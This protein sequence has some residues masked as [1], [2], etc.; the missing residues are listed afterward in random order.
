MSTIAVIHIIRI[1]SI[2]PLLLMCMLLPFD[3]PLLEELDPALRLGLLSLL[4]RLEAGMEDP[5]LQLDIPDVA[6]NWF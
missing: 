3:L 2:D 1:L 6:M 4:L 5:L